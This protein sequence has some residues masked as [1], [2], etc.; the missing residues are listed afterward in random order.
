MRVA[1]SLGLTLV[2]GMSDVLTERES[3][4][5]GGI[6]PGSITPKATMRNALYHGVSEVARSEATRQAEAIGQE[7][8]YVTVDAGTD[9][10]VSLTKAYVAK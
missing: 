5:G 9:L 2:A 3:L 6:L 8:E 10:I 7:Q 4:G 1:S